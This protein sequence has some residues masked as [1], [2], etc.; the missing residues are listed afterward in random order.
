MVG[1]VG[2][3]QRFKARDDGGAL[4]VD[5]CKNGVA[6]RE[7]DCFGV[8]RWGFRGRQLLAANADARQRCAGGVLRLRCLLPR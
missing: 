1:K 2:E 7:C 5:G 8:N 6:V 3:T 4:L